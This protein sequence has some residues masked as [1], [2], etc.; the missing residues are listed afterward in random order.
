MPSAAAPHRPF[1]AIRQANHCLQ[2]SV[3]VSLIQAAGRGDAGARLGPDGDLLPLPQ[4]HWV[5]LW[6]VNVVESPFAALRLRTDAAKRFKR[7]DRAPNLLAKVY[8]GVRYLHGIR[9]Y[10]GGRGLM[11]NSTPL[12]GTSRARC[13]PYLRLEKLWEYGFDLLLIDDHAGMSMH[14]EPGCNL[15][16]FIKDERW[17]ANLYCTRGSQ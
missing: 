17:Y 4:E 14:L 7:C 6:T 2:R 15:F 8:A 10:P 3:R 13:E 5:H 1:L 16:P 11:R 9:G 12:G